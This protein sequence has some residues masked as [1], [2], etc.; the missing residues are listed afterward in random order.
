MSQDEWDQ[1][2]ATDLTS[3]FRLSRLCLRS[4]VKARWGRIINIA[5]VL[6]YT[7][8]AGQANYAAAKAGVVGFS[9]SLALEVA[10]RSI[11]VNCVAPGF[12]ET[13]MTKGL[14]DKITPLTL[15]SG[16]GKWLNGCISQYTFISLILLAIN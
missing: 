1:V 14:P 13:D 4:M 3:V 12:I 15:S 5:S 16:T 6:A 9:K 10:S 11:T 2:I 7:G 8:N